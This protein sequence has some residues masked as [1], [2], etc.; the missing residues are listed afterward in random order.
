MTEK[1]EH[2]V[3]IVENK[4]EE[5]LVSEVYLSA[6][7]YDDAVHR[8]KTMLAHPNVIRCCIAKLEFAEGN[9]SLLD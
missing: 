9:R 6:C 2:F 7:S 4:N 3:V 5:P 8:M 1:P